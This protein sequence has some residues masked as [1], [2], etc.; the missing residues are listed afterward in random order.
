MQRPQPIWTKSFISLFCTNLSVFVVFYGLTATLPLYATGILNKTDQEAGLLMSIFLLSAIIVRPFTGKI[1]DLAGKRRMLWISLA[2]Y[3]FCT[4]LYYFIEPFGL[5]LVLRFLHG[6]GFSI[7]TTAGGA[8]AADLVPAARRGTGLGYFTMSTNLGV[9]LGPLVSLTLIQAYSFDALFIILSLLMVTGALFSL[10]IPDKIQASVKSKRKLSLNDLFEKN[11]LP[12]AF[13]GCLIGLSYAS[14]LSYLSIYAQ[15]KGLLD[16]TGT[17]FLVFAAVMLLARPFTGRLF[18]VKG[19][20]YILYPGLVLFIIG[21]IMLAYTDSAVT[22]LIAGGF[23]GL[24]YGSLVPSLLTLAIQST[25]IERSGYATAT[26]Y[27]FFDGGIAL[28]SYIFGMIAAATSYHS[29]YLISGA[30][31]GFVFILLNLMDRKKQAEKVPRKLES[32]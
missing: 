28:G 22:F 29:I 32:L 7:V 11:A 23:V 20:Q 4:V 13:L 26:F 3:L 27:T 5:L 10:M 9:V 8:L 18:D 31:V 19:P 2:L 24:G 14:I 1:L 12:V 15:G 16:M 17:F 21:L 30:L 6:I 25:Q